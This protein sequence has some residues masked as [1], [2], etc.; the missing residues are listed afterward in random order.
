MRKIKKNEGSA[1]K[2]VHF[3]SKN[4]LMW[5]EIVLSFVAFNLG[6]LLANKDEEARAKSHFVK[7]VEKIKRDAK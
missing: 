7:M 3:F 1:K 4:I 2:C 5:L 6:Y